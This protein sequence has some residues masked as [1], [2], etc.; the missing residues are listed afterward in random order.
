MATTLRARCALSPRSRTGFSSKKS[1]RVGNVRLV[2]CGG[3]SHDGVGPSK[4]KFVEFVD[5]MTTLFP[6]WVATAAVSALWRPNLYT[7]FSGDLLVN[8]IAFTMLGMGLTM[9]AKDFQ[10]VLKV[11]KA[12][13]VGL[14]LQ[15]TVMPTMGFLASKIATGV[16]GLPSAYAAGLI[17]VSCCPGGTASNIVSYLANADVPLSVLMTAASTTS[18]VFATPFLT[19]GLIGT[20]V[21]VDGFGL[22]VSTLK[23]VLLPVLLGVMLNTFAPRTVAKVSK[24]SPLIA[25]IIV[26]LCCGSVIGQNASSILSAGPALVGVVAFLHAGGFLLGYSLTRLGGYGRRTA[27]TISIEVGMQNSALGA[28]L[29]TLHFA[30]PLT[31][32]PCAVSACVH[33]LLGS[34]LAGLWRTQPVS[35]SITPHTVL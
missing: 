6:A 21:P 4:T 8:G 22:F 18:A 30:D 33:S 7:W 5:G 10:E 19:T 25:V 3:V 23:V 16:I 11:P 32:A 2:R 31:A 12:M 27:R 34:M 35:K 13:L 28:I 26:A 9:E 17:L 20:L 29:A 14:T 1:C 15:Y 24:I